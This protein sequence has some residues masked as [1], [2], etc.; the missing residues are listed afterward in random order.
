MNL[1]PEQIPAVTNTQ[2]NNS[3]QNSHTCK[4]QIPTSLSD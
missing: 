1:M 2:F 3:S 4:V